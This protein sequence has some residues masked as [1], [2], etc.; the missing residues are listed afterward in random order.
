MY[1]LLNVAE[2][3]TASARNLPDLLIPYLPQ[4]VETLNADLLPL[5]LKMSKPPSRPPN[6][7]VA[8]LL[9]RLLPKV[10]PFLARRA[11]NA[12]N[13]YSE[14]TSPIVMEYFAKPF[15]QEKARMVEE[16]RR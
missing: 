6:E 5:A 2:S 4:L 9:S 1:G 16:D 10:L 12:E 11:A 14:V 15:A 8:R 13:R 3:H 7:T